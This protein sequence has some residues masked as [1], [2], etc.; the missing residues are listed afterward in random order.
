MKTLVGIVAVA[1]SVFAV[2][3][4][5]DQDLFPQVE[6]LNEKS[7]QIVVNEI[8]VD[9]AMADINFESDFFIG[10]EGMM[11]GMQGGG[12]MQDGGMHGGRMNW[13]SNNSNH[14]VMGQSPEFSMHG[15]QGQYPDSIVMNYG[16]GMQLNNGRVISGSMIINTSEEPNGNGFIRQI[17]YDNFFADSMSITGMTSMYISGFNHNGGKHNLTEDLMITLPDG[18]TIQRESE[19]MREWIAGSETNF[20]QTDDVMQ[21]T[22][23]VLNTVSENG[24]E[25]VYRKD[26]LEPMVKSTNCRYFSQ[27]IVELSVNGN[28]I[29]TLDYGKGDCDDVAS[30]TNAGEKTVE[31][32]LSENDRCAK[33]QG[34]VMNQAT[35][36]DMGMGMGTSA[37]MGMSQDSM[38]YHAGNGTDDNHQGEGSGMSQDSTGHDN[39]MGMGTGQGSSTGNGMGMGN[40]SGMGQG[41]TTGTGTS[42]G[43]TNGTGM[44]LGTSTGSGTGMG[45][46]NGKG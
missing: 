42:M 9:N 23:Y 8:S 45:Q 15:N 17:T 7:A 44:G 14:Y 30:L 19:I 29:A 11:T 21:I 2:S 5:K 28:V 38:G 27:G 32:I 34:H 22:G 36:T 1:L 6:N 31:I 41:T 13:V 40:S 33:I 3:C 20:D 43:N 35:S 37:G 18:T 12:M 26:I 39:G 16:M 10:A 25:T 24:I 4:Q 46:G